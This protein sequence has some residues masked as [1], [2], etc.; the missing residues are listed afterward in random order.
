MA[1][2]SD[3]DIDDAATLQARLPSVKPVSHFGEISSWTEGQ[4]ASNYYQKSYEICMGEMKK[5]DFAPLNVMRTR[6]S[7]SMFHSNAVRAA[8]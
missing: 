4:V 6:N 1:T 3:S 8:A 5:L 7:A 2:D